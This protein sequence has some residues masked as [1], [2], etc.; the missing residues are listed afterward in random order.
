MIN[1]DDVIDMSLYSFRP[2][3]PEVQKEFE[4]RAHSVDD[5]ENP[6]I[7]YDSKGKL[8]ETIDEE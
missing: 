3:D 5:N 7:I 1:S 8:G 6:P 2:M 4:R